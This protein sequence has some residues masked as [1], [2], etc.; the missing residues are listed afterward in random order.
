[1]VEERRGAQIG[2]DELQNLPKVLIGGAK[3]LLDL[4]LPVL[5]S[6]QRRNYSTFALSAEFFP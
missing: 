2:A 1:L 4:D 5:L 3:K 6:L